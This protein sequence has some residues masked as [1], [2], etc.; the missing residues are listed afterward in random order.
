MTVTA[1]LDAAR[2][3]LRD[4]PREA[5]G[6]LVRPRRMLGVARAARILPRGTAWHIGVLLLT[7]E[8]VLATGQIVRA[9]REVRRGY[10][11][12]S[13]RS[14]A[15][16]AA[17]AYRGGFAEGDAVHIGWRRLD[18]AVIDSGGSDEP[19]QS[20]GG[21]PSVRWSGA[22]APMPLAAYLDE[23]IALLLDP[24]AGA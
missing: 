24:P 17:A 4:A 10:A 19:L 6:E 8:D 15:E 12:E 7:D 14:R 13:Q 2:S 21:V 20:P 3:R 5:L 22:G 18:P 9:R 1:L 23:R 11:A 16:L